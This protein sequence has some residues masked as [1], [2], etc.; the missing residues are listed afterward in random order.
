M[1]EPALSSTQPSTATTWDAPAIGSFIVGPGVASYARIPVPGTKGLVL[2]LRP[3]LDWRG[4]STSSVFIQ[5]PLDRKFGKPYLRLDYGYNKSTRVFDYHWNIVGKDARAAFPGI[6]NHMPAGRTG[7]ALY[8]SARAFR[9]AGSIFIVSGAVLDGVSILVADRPLR[10]SVQVVAA[11][12]AAA[13]F[14]AR[15]GRLGA[16][17]GSF[18]E[19]GAGTAI[20]GGIGALAGGVI[21]YFTA[22]RV[23]GVVYDWA[24]DTKFTAAVPAETPQ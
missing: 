12:E 17:A 8:E 3:P 18:V 1:A 2:S 15:L 5:S 11:W 23:A 10:R 21:G 16:F 24:A 14:A 22:E 4:G 20:G 7:A 13:V 9:I 6:T 19:P